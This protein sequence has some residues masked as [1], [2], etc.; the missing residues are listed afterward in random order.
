MRERQHLAMTATCPEGEA[1]AASRNWNHGTHF[2]WDPKAAPT[3]Q[4]LAT[5]RHRVNT[6]RSTFQLSTDVQIAARGSPARCDR[7]E[8]RGGRSDIRLYGYAIFPGTSTQTGGTLAFLIVVS[9]QMRLRNELMLEEGFWRRRRLRGFPRE[10]LRLWLW[11]GRF[12]RLS[13]LLFPAVYISV[14][15]PEGG[16]GNPNCHSCFPCSS[17]VGPD[18]FNGYS[19]FFVRLYCTGLGFQANIVEEYVLLSELLHIFAGLKRTRDQK[20]SSGL[21]S[22]QWSLAVTGSSSRNMFC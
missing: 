20:L 21:M 15:S 6:A 14:F 16:A 18:D 5:Q 10:S 2:L 3:F 11:R 19:Y 9:S 1:W 8:A 7:V 17:V 12:L 22:C 4:P 13:L